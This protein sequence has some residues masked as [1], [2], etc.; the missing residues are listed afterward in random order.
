MF[1]AEKCCC[2]GA[3]EDNSLVCSKCGHKLTGVARIL[4]SLIFVVGGIE[5]LLSFS[6]KASMLGG[7]EYL[8]PLFSIIPGVLMAFVGLVLKL[9]GG[10]ALLVG[11]RVREAALALV[12][13]V[14]LATLMFHVGEGQL[15]NALKNL[16]IIGGLLAVMATGAGAFV[17]CKA[18]KSTTPKE[19]NSE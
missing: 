9:V 5:F 13:Y 14:A 17:M 6:D 12:V 4:L 10:T 7:K 8:I 18:G 2:G 16:A 11:Y 3:T 19:S 15:T 1:N